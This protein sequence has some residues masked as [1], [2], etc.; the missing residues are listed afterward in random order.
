[1]TRATRRFSAARLAF[2]LAILAP[3]GAAT[4]GGCSSG[5]KTVPGD[6]PTGG[7]GAL[8]GGGAANGGAHSGASAGVLGMAGEA[9]Q[10]RAGAGAADGGEGGGAAASPQ[11]GESGDSSGN[12]GSGTSSGG[13]SSG[14]M[15]H[16]GGHGG[17]AGHSAGAG[18]GAGGQTVAKCGDKVTTP[19]E[20]CDDGT[21]TDLSYGCAACTTLPKGKAPEGAQQCD[22]C[23]AG[24]S[25]SCE[26]CNDY[27]ACYACLREQAS[28]L[29][30][31]GSAWC[32]NI[33]DDDVLDDY[34]THKSVSDRCFDPDNSEYKA[35]TGGPA[36]S[37]SRG[38]VC[39]ALVA[40]VLRTGCMLGGDPG[41]NM[42]RNCYCG[43]GK[44]EVCSDPMFVPKGPCAK[45]IRDADAPGASTIGS[46]LT[47]EIAQNLGDPAPGN[48]YSALGVANQIAVCAADTYGCVDVCFPKSSSTGG[49]GGTAGTAGAGGSSGHGGS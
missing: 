6:C 42:F 20:F 5:V 47:L 17:A 23:L 41:T 46:G 29:R 49:A 48:H 3:L 13:T 24:K 35:A 9:G 14:G 18:N 25:T 10:P 34:T 16:T 15:S 22:T 1:M 32:P 28:D 36:G 44:G 45:E 21:N 43:A 19:P 8:G 37:E 38:L 2:Q 12:A 4:F 27:R 33:V 7:T 39:Q 26:L 40:C 30:F 11:G 31:Q